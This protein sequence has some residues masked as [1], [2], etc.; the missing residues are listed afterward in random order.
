MITLITSIIAIQDLTVFN[1]L[2]Q[3][4]EVLHKKKKK[5]KGKRLKSRTF[6]TLVDNQC[7]FPVA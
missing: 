4:Q 1:C 2:P 6:R 5:K 7:S 3:N